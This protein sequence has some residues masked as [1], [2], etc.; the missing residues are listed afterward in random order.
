M[1]KRQRTLIVHKATKYFAFI[2]LFTIV[3]DVSFREFIKNNT[4]TDEKGQYS[5]NDIYR[6]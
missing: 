5:K 1:F 3:E 6:A 4:N 2:N